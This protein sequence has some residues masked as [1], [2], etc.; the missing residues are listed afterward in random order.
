MV[1]IPDYVFRHVQVELGAIFYKQVH[2]RQVGAVT[3]S[4]VDRDDSAGDAQS[5]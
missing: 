4:V 2:S 1:M 3:S 5:S